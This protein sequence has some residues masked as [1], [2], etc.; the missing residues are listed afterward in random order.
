MCGR[1]TCA[2]L[3]QLEAEYRAELAAYNSA[4]TNLRMNL[5]LGKTD[6]GGGPFSDMPA[7]VGGICQYDLNGIEWCPDAGGSHAMLDAMPGLSSFLMSDPVVNIVLSLPLSVMPGG[8]ELD[9]A[10]M[11][12][13]ATAETSTAIIG[14]VAQAQA[15]LG[16]SVID[17]NMSAAMQAAAEANPGLLNAFRGTLLHRMTADALDNLYG[18]GRFIY[19][20]RG[21][22]FTDTATGDQVELTTL[23]QIAAHIARGGDYANP[24]TGYATYILG[25]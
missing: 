3:A 2:Y 11:E 22:D 5:R 4:I 12:F 6:Q 10:V 9:A 25:G 20:T 8:D 23:R 19:S 15:D 17:A 7:G 14:R 18:L 1:I 13:E 24:A 21:V 16:T